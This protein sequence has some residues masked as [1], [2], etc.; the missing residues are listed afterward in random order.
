M[1]TLP[2]RR[3]AAK[4]LRG[5]IDLDVTFQDAG[6]P[7]ARLTQRVTLK[8]AASASVVH[9]FEE[10]VVFSGY[11]PGKVG[12]SSARV[13]S[14]GADGAGHAL[15][16]EVKPK[17]EDNSVLFHP[18]LP[19]VVERVEMMVKGGD[20]P[21]T[22]Q[23]W[24]ID[25]GYTGI[26]LRPYNLFWAE[27]IIVDWQGW[28]KVVVPAPP[29]P[30]HFGDKN[31]SFLFRP[32]YPLHL[33]LNARADGDTPVELRIDDVRVVTHLSEDEQLRFE[34]EYPD[35]IRLHAP[36]APLRLVVWNFAPE[37]AALAL[38]YE[39][40]NY[41]GFTAR[42][43]KVDVRVPAGA[44]QKVTL[45]PS[46]PAGIFDLDI[47]GTG[48]EPVAGCVMA[49]DGRRYFGNEPLD[50]LVD[51]LRLR[52]QLGLLAERT[53][54]DWDNFE[55][56]PYLFHYN[57]FEEELK[58]V[59]A[60][61][62]LP[63]ELA[64]VAA[65]NDAAVKVATDAE[66]ALRTAQQQIQNALGMER[67][68]A[69]KVEASEKLLPPARAEE[70]TVAKQATTAM[71]KAE[72]AGKDADNAKA[73]AADALKA[74][75]AAE[76]TLK[77][78]QATAQM[79]EKEQQSALAAIKDAE[80]KVVTAQAA[81]ATADKD[82]TSAAAAAKAA[83]ADPKQ[84]DKVKALRDRAEELM[85]KTLA[86][87]ASLETARAL[88]AV[89]K[90]DA[91]KL[92]MLGETARKTVQAE[93]TKVQ[94]AK[95]TH[96]QMMQK[97]TTATQAAEQAKRDSAAAAQRLQAAKG[98][99]ANLAKMLDADRAAHADRVN[100]IAAAKEAIEKAETALEDARTAAE[101]A[102]KAF[103]EAKTPYALRPVPVV[104]FCAEW[105]GRESADALQR[106][107]YNRWIPN[108]LQLPRRLIDWSE[109]VRATQREYRGRFDSW[110]FWENPDLEDS[111]QSIPPKTYRPM[112]DVFSKWVK[113]YSPDAKVV[114]GGFN[115]PRAVDYLAKIKDAHTLPFDEIAVQMNLGELSPEHAD[116]E[117]FLDEMNDILK[118]SQTKKVVRPTEL[119][120]SIGKHLSPLQQ[121][122]YH[123]RAT[124]ILDSRG[125]PAHQLS[126]INT[127]FDF[128]GFGVFYRASYGSSPEVQ[129]FKPY[130]VPK[131]SYF[132]LTESR[133]FL[134]EWKFVT[135]VHP[136]DR[137]LADNRAFVYRN[138]D[139][140]LTAALWRAVGG[141]RVYRVPAGWRGA[142]ARDIFG[143]EA[144][145][146][147]G[148]SC[149]PLPTLVEMPAGY[150]LEQLLHD[151]RHLQSADGSHPVVLD[152]HA[153]EEDSARR[154][155]Y[156]TTGTIR[157]AVRSGAILGE[158][159]VRE[160]YLEGVQSEKFAFQS[161]QAGNL[162]LKRRWY[163][164]G[165]G[166][167]LFVTLNG[168]AEQSWDLSKELSRTALNAYLS[169]M[170]QHQPLAAAACSSYFVG[171]ETGLRETTFVLRGCKAGKNEI[172]IRHD[173]PGNGAGW[174][175][176]PM[177]EDH[178]PLDRL[179]M[180]NGRQTKGEIVKHASAAGT[181]LTLEKKAYS[182]GLGMQATSFIEYP[183]AG[184]FS[185]LEVTVGID[186]VTEGRGSVVCR[187]FVDGKERASSG[188]VSGFSK[189]NTLKVD[190]LEG[191]RRLILS[192]TDAGDG[193]RDDLA[194]WVEGKLTLKRLE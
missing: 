171:N 71:T 127:G 108:R 16:L 73:A 69:Q 25:S 80:A 20:R 67:Q 186:A 123:A 104:G 40:R 141:E 1:T 53:Y 24:L 37:P 191:A 147:T 89:R 63:P 142:K 158:R 170:L 41:Q 36:G 193:N 9:D 21:V 111:P 164:D 92:R 50:V 125:V 146:E 29:V 62:M 168:G 194:N 161:P 132:A 19:G 137:S 72:A 140:R 33:A 93:T 103:E 165:V 54:L 180:L 30:A 173:I 169:I 97:A 183:L 149:T 163:F 83:E 60:L 31:R 120:W 112:L 153:G 154:A 6:R 38:R 192:V 27:P 150:A 131:P 190:R 4:K 187:V 115:F 124:L 84:K 181:P 172:V 126:I 82:A 90:T 184:Q 188:I 39:L 133:R 152:L 42:S 14:G 70:E 17:Q 10:P 13:V 64:G 101:A 179:G 148:L 138:K 130:H 122:A 5:P 2:L 43:G 174:R 44:K 105:A 76:A 175:L 45:V 22:I 106:A 135:S 109:F 110:V 57:W 143:F 129:T 23:P 51:P 116:L 86:A 99:V 121:A 117:G 58:K 155:G 55:A 61:P 151:L 119:D 66:Q 77:T 18:A 7:G 118:V 74:V 46:L 113:L 49:L 167:K 47:R 87:K 48:K 26:W 128:E 56:A 8:A 91:E 59:R 182:T 3:L 189:P 166:S 34:V 145:L 162:L 98:K 88:V 75:Q 134:S 157:K 176:E 94:A 102:G 11:Q 81:Q 65:K 160:T 139:G 28:K 107:V 100:G 144:S 79:T 95:Q 78:A 15:A 185:A 12:K 96:Q 68:A 136:P 35:E 178:L 177:P 114:A 159:K 52:R 156:E 32:W 85:K